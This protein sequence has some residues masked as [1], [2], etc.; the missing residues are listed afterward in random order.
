MTAPQRIYVVRNSA[1]D[2]DADHQPSKPTARLVRAPNAAQALRY[3]A[4]DTLAVEVA[5]QDT[6]IE[7]VAAGVTVEQ[8]GRVSDNKEN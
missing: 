5:S 2:F 1:A 8:S 6:L 3:V 4:A 7:L